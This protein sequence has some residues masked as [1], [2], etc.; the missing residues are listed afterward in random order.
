MSSEPTSTTKA[1]RS[2]RE[3]AHK[4][5]VAPSPPSHS[6]KAEMPDFLSLQYNDHTSSYWEGSTPS[7]DCSVEEPWQ[8]HGGL[9]ADTT[10]QSLVGQQPSIAAPHP[11]RH[12]SDRNQLVA[13]QP[14]HGNAQAAH[15]QIRLPMLPQFDMPPQHLAEQHEVYMHPEVKYEPSAAF[16]L[17][18]YDP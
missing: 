17:H 11:L 15:A 10:G 8:F 13:S 18:S 12:H 9:L 6:I 5:A 2:R 7:D 4:D 14:A 3:T 16:G 1:R